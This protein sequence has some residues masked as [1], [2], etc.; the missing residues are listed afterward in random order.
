M[1]LTDFQMSCLQLM[2]AEQ[3]EEFNTKRNPEVLSFGT[4]FFVKALGLKRF[5]HNHPKQMAVL[6]QF[7]WV[8]IWQEKNG[9]K[10]FAVKDAAMVDLGDKLTHAKA[11]MWRTGIRWDE[12]GDHKNEPPPFGDPLQHVTVEEIYKNASD[13]QLPLDVL[14]EEYRQKTNLSLSS[15][16][17]EQTS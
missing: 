9:R 16:T 17:G 13:P 11:D 3:E 12:W 6:K 8:H 2:R 1:S 7:G 14:I 4:S 5:S 15:L 10:Y